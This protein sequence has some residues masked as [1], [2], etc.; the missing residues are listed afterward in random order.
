MLSYSRYVVFAVFF[1]SAGFVHRS[2]F[3][4]RYRGIDHR[5]LC[6]ESETIHFMK[7]VRFVCGEQ[8]FFSSDFVQECQHRHR[9]ALDSELKLIQ[10][11]QNY[12]IQLVAAS[13][14]VL[15]L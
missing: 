2:V 11:V 15:V 12:N 4:S 5:G 7:R 8:C 9:Y 3:F 6:R 10:V 13:Y 1:P 14:M